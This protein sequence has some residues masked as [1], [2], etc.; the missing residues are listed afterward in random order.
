MSADPAFDLR[1][2]HVTGFLIAQLAD[3][4]GSG[5]RRKAV[6]RIG[7]NLHQDDHCYANEE[8]DIKEGA[9]Y[10]VTLLSDFDQEAVK[11][12]VQLFQVEDSAGVAAL[13]IRRNRLA[14]RLLPLGFRVHILQGADFFFL[15]I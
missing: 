7:S 14:D 1:F 10:L 11:L 3:T 9:A 13:E 15:Q 2:N 5:Q 6:L 4:I 8:A 12:R